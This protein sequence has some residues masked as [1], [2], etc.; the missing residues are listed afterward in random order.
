MLAALSLS[1]CGLPLFFFIQ[2]VG[3]AIISLV[4]DETEEKKKERREEE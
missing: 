2:I 1:F 4:A 3:Q